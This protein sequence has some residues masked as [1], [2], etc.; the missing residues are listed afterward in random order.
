VFDGALPA[1]S[2][3]EAQVTWGQ[4]ATKRSVLIVPNGMPRIYS[5]S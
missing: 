5:H 3:I 1:V 2:P 4:G